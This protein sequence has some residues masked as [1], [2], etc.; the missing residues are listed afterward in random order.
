MAEV[1]ERLGVAPA[2][3]SRL[4]DRAVVGGYV[5]KNPSRADARRLSLALTPTGIALRS[6]SEAFRLAY[7][8]SVLD[9]WTPDEV[10]VFERLLTRFA[11]TVH[12]HPPAAHSGEGT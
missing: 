5:V 7:L 12:S 2:T 4:C 1:A 8:T 10:E 11:E 3:A 9:H 6:R